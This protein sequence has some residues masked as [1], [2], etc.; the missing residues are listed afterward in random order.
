LPLGHI[1]NTHT[2][3]WLDDL[4]YEDLVFSQLEEAEEDY[5]PEVEEDEV[6]DVD[7]PME[8]QSSTKPPSR[9]R[10]HNYCQDKYIALCHSWMN[11]SRDA[12]VVTD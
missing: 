7:D 8:I 4:H 3:A 2:H 12:S 5:E 10:T 6:V 9:S 1:S 11:V